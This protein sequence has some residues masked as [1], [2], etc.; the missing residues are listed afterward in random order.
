MWKSQWL[1]KFSKNLIKEP[2]NQ[3]IK[4]EDNFYWN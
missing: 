3:I 2:L 1:E 4:D